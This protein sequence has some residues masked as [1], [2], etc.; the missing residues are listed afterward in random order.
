MQQIKSED[1]T[2]LIALTLCLLAAFAFIGSTL[3]RHN[4]ENKKEDAKR[5]R[6]SNLLLQIPSETESAGSM[7]MWRTAKSPIPD[8]FRNIGNTYFE[9]TPPPA[10]S[11][12]VRPPSNGG[13]TDNKPPE[14]K[15]NARVIQPIIV[16]KGVIISDSG[17]GDMAVFTVGDFTKTLRVG[18]PVV[19]GLILTA[20]TDDGV[21]IRDLGKTVKL[22]LNES[23][24]PVE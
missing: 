13:D 18:Q 7:I 11:P 16:L 17:L 20:L 23:Y 12:P 3:F 10:N 6:N 1:K 15:K 4:S 21:T 2:K 19:T 24:K 5:T 22:S 8:P 9:P 14:V